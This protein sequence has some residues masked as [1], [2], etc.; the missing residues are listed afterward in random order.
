MVHHKARSS[1]PGGYFQRRW[2]SD[3]QVSPS[4]RDRG[5]QWFV[6][7]VGEQDVDV[8][9]ANYRTVKSAAEDFH[10]TSK[11][12]PRL[13][14]PCSSPLTCVSVQQ[15]M[16]STPCWMLVQLINASTSYSGVLHSTP[17]LAYNPHKKRKHYYDWKPS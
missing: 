2:I 8:Y 3:P 17:G 9:I 12:R 1:R 4:A 6:E 11:L 7:A 10:D 14:I 15:I 16:G 13:F 5:F